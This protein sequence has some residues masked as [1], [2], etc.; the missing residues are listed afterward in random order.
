MNC[1]PFQYFELP[2]NDRLWLQ[3]TGMTQQLCA[4]LILKSSKHAIGVE[5]SSEFC[6]TR[7]C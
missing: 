1:H 6:V 2:V 7:V 4:K 3:G 5:H